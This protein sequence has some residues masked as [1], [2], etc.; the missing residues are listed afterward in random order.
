M[1]HSQ[2]N[3][4]G[5]W[6]I[7][8]QERIELFQLFCYIIWNEE[9]FFGNGLWSN[10]GTWDHKSDFSGEKKNERTWFFL[11]IEFQLLWSEEASVLTLSLSIYIFLSFSLARSLSQEIDTISGKWQTKIV[12][13]SIGSAWFR[14][15]LFSINQWFDLHHHQSNYISY[16]PHWMIHWFRR[17]MTGKLN[18]V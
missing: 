9:K 5:I 12:V 10:F 4:S 18:R 6:W 11:P 3:K 17:N 15:S 7:A 14:N 2:S 1:R 13:F 16:W 8:S